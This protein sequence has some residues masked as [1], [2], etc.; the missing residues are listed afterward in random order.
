MEKKQE[1]ILK[2][3]EKYD[4]GSGKKMFTP[5][6]CSYVPK[7]SRFKKYFENETNFQPKSI[8]EKNLSEQKKLFQTAEN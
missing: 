3:S 1:L 8:F 7:S 5:E 4:L 2:T 6:T